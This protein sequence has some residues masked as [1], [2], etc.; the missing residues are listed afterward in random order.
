[1]DFSQPHMR[2]RRG[3]YA[4]LAV[5]GAGILM[6]IALVGQPMVT[7]VPSTPPSV[8]PARREAHVKKLSV[9]LYPRSF[10]HPAKLERAAAYIAEQLKGTGALATDRLPS[11]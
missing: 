3:I 6:L 2:G 11:A 9:E 8:D 7:P 1:M 5:I 4:A 10:E